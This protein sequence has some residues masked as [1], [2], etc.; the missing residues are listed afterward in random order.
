MAKTTRTLF[1]CLSL[2]LI[3]LGCGGDGR[4]AEKTTY[5]IKDQILQGSIGGKP[6]Q[7]V[8]GEARDEDNAYS[9]W[10]LSFALFPSDIETCD[11][12]VNF[13]QE[14]HVRF[15]CAEKD[16][17]FDLSLENTV[18]IIDYEGGDPVNYIVT[19]G[20]VRWNVVSSTEV[21]G[22]MHV[23]FDENNQVNGI[24]TITRCIEE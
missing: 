17:E 23:E 8:K 15:G 11:F 6:W 14:S 18:T 5:E 9:G 24:F 19:K 21:Q 13:L 22:G 10:D 1:V 4:D 20:T 7:F 3:V 16:K 12:G 2:D